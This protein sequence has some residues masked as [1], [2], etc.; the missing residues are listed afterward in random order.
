[1]NILANILPE[2]D[3]E[4]HSLMWA[5]FRALQSDFLWIAFPRL[6]YSI[7]KLSQSGLI[8]LVIQFIDNNDKAVYKKAGLMIAAAI[9]YSCL[10]VRGSIHLACKHV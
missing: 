9:V 3:D 6:C 4:S 2:A 5:A 8:Y 7:A 1:M 10:A